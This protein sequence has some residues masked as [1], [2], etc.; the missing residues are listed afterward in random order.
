[1]IL[2]PKSMKLLT[3]YFMTADRKNKLYMSCDGD[4]PS[5][6][7]ANFLSQAVNMDFLLT[8]FRMPERVNL[9]GLDVFSELWQKELVAEATRHFR[10]FKIVQQEILLPEKIYLTLLSK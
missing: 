6:T 3:L 1:M 4:I 8:T 5:V 2:Q 7:K 10:S 9:S